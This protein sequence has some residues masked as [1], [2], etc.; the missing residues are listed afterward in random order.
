MRQTNKVSLEYLNFFTDRGVDVIDYLEQAYGK[1]TE[2]IYEGI[3]KGNIS[4]A[5]AADIILKGLSKTSDEGGYKGGMSLQAKSFLGIQSTYEDAWDSIYATAA[6][7][8]NSIIQEGREKQLEMLEGPTGSFIKNAYSEIAEA[9][10]NLESSQKRLELEAIEAVRTGIVG[11]SFTTE[12]NRNRLKALSEEYWKGGANRSAVMAEAQTIAQAEYEASTEFQSMKD[13]HLTL[14]ENVRNDTQLQDEYWDTGFQ[15]GEA[16]SVG[17]KAAIRA[18]KPFKP[19]V[20]T[21]ESNDLT[22]PDMVITNP[23]M[24]PDGTARMV[25]P[26]IFTGNA[27]GL[28]YVPRDDYLAR[29]HEGEMVLTAS[30]ARA[31]REGGAPVS[32][33]MNGATIREE[34]DIYKIAQAL[35]EELRRAQQ[36]S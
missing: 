36:V 4:G 5:A 11:D 29:L 12:E 31:Y 3:S 16:F 7:S 26:S 1:T 30:Q 33:Q 6:E 34:A 13:A 35:A 27:Y 19:G 8:Y 25:D 32:V 17:I 2:Q 14:I 18:N 15:F 22:N 28:S 20:L 23:M 21:P 24:N 10:A 9:Q